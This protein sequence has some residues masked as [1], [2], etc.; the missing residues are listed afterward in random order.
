MLYPRMTESE[1]YDYGKLLA[2]DISTASATVNDAWKA[3]GSDYR[4]DFIASGNAG[5]NIQALSDALIV[6]MDKQAKDENELPVGIKAEC[7]TIS[8]PTN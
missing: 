7:P 1:G 2:G 5:E 4:A 8:C 6:M 3:D